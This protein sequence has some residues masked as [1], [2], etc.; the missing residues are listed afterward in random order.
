M[1]I[2]I[3]KKIFG[4]S[5]AVST[6]DP[7]PLV[8]PTAGVGLPLGEEGIDYDSVMANLEYKRL[9]IEQVRDVIVSEIKETYNS[10]VRAIKAGD[11][12]TAELLA[13]EA[14][15]KKNIVKALNLVAK[16]LK[17]AVARIKTAKTAEEAVKALGPVVAVLRS[18]NPYLVNVSPEL[19]TQIAAI[20]DEIERLYSVP[21]VEVRGLDSRSV[22]DLVP[23]ARE[24]L[25][26]V[27]KEVDDD[28]DRVFQLDKKEAAVEMG[29]N[30]ASMARKASAEKSL[31]RGLSEPEEL[32]PLLL[33]YIKRNGGKLNIKRA[34]EELGLDVGS[35]RL[36]LEYLQEKGLIKVRNARAE[37]VKY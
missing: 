12:E 23:E 14:A 2:S 4:R 11:R 5:E 15:L 26:E 37:A 25:K 20:R 24:V 10:I 7:A 35:I 1:V 3:I 32:A 33:D 29:R 28:L 19:A 18:L 22:M 30:S 34:A 9:E 31:K 8:D 6:W 17:L 36:T 27:A 16:L 13:A 21:G